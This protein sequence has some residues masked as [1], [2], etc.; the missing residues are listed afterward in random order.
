MNDTDRIMSSVDT[1]SRPAWASPPPVRLGGL[2][3]GISDVY[4]YQYSNRNILFS[5]LH[6]DC[7]TLIVI[8]NE[9]LT[10][11]SYI[12]QIIFVIM[13]YIVVVCSQCVYSLGHYDTDAL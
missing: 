4:I 9:I 8:N 11:D 12:A 10:F 1:L 3:V 6:T 13:L 2:K 7:I 5:I